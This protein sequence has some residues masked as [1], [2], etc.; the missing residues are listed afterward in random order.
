MSW[1][2][3][4]GVPATSAGTTTLI[5]QGRWASPASAASRLARGAAAVQLDHHLVGLEALAVRLRRDLRPLRHGEFPDGAAVVADGKGG[6]PPVV[7]MPAGDEG[8]EALD[9]V[10]LL[11][12]RHTLQ[13][14]VNL[15]RRPK[16]VHAQGIEDLVR[17]RRSSEEHKSE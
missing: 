16:A 9:A 11:A 14:A 10:H 8:V 12:L 1:W 15:H 13:G 17:G 4:H 2:R 5:W 7:E 3:N 6:R